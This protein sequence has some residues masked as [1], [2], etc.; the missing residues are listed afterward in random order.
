MSSFLSNYIN[1]NKR[2]RLLN[3][4]DIVEKY[5]CDVCNA[6]F[7]RRKDLSNHSRIHER[8]RDKTTL[9]NT[10]EDNTLGEGEKFDEDLSS[11]NDDSTNDEIRKL[12]ILLF[13]RYMCSPL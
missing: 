9:D 8:A 4:E 3:D 13:F 5:N 10:I 12:I 11:E 7:T 2:T 1:S 6:G